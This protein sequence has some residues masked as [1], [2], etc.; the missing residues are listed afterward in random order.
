MVNF[1]PR[2][3]ISYKNSQGCFFCSYFIAVWNKSVLKFLVFENSRV[4]NYAS[5]LALCLFNQWQ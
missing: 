2:E 4:K 1:F 3:K 5:L